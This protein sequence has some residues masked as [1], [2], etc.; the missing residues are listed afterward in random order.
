MSRIRLPLATLAVVMLAGCHSAAPT[1]PAAPEERAAS[2]ASM[3][4]SAFGAAERGG[5]LIGSG[6]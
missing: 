3:P 2:T 6:T 5:S 1:A 4:D